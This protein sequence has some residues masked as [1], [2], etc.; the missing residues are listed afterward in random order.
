MF[1][2]FNPSF[3]CAP[4]A[5]EH[6]GVPHMWAVGADDLLFIYIYVYILFLKIL[7]NYWKSHLYLKYSSIYWW[8]YLFVIC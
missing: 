7:K 8:I 5:F 1:S 6:Q 3:E 4:L 2:I